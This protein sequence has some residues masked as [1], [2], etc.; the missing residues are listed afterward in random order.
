MNHQDKNNTH[1][2]VNNRDDNNSSTQEM[3]P[4]SCTIDT[5]TE[6]LSQHA[7]KEATSKFHALPSNHFHTG[8][9]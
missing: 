7:H 6:H 3:L 9:M 5:G 8:C 4:T 2:D 1:N